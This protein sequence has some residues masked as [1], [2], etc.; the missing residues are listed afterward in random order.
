MKIVISDLNGVVV[1]RCGLILGEN[2]ATGVRKVFKY[3]AGLRD[4]TKK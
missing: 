1:A 2:N 4:H 3:L